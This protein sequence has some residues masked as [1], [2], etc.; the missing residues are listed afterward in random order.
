MENP[1]E[2]DPKKMSGKPVF[3]GTRIPVFF[4]S[5]YL[6]DGYTVEDFIDVYDIGPDLVW[7]VYRENF[8]DGRESGEKASA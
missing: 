3:R 6:N 1:I 4:L 7:Q 5:Q 2:V 8:Q